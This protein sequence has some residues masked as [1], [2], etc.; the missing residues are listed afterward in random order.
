MSFWRTFGFHTISQVETIL[1]REHFTLEELLDEEELL[2]ECKSHN[3]KLIEYLAKTETLHQLITYLTVEPD[4]NAENKRKMR[5]PL[6]ACEILCSELWAV[7]DAIFEN[8]GHLDGL[9]GYLNKPTL[10]PMLVGYISKVVGTLL[11]KKSI[12][13]MN[14]L[15]NKKDA[16]FGNLLK[17]LDNPSI[18]ELLIKIIG[19]E[20][21]EPNGILHW[22]SEA[23][24]ISI[25]INKLSPMY[26][27]EVHENAAQ[28]LVEITLISHPSSPLLAQIE[29]QEAITQLFDLILA[30]G[31][32]PS[33]LSSGLTILMELFKKTSQESFNTQAKL[34]TLAPV[35]SVLVKN[36]E[37]FNKLL[38]DPANKSTLTLTTGTIVPLGIIRLKIVEFI[39]CL[40]KTNYA[41]LHHELVTSGLLNACLDL[42]F[43]FVWNNFLHATM[44]CI[45]AT[46]FDGENQDLKISLVKDCHLFDRIV[47][48]NKEN[49]AAVAEPKGMRR[50]NMAFITRIA[51]LICLEAQRNEPLAKL[52]EAHEGWKLFV[53]TSL[54]KT[55]Q[56]EA[57]LGGHKPLS[58]EPTTSEEEEEGF[59]SNGSPATL[60]FTQY[61]AQQ[62]FTNVYP[63][64]YNDEEYEDGEGERFFDAD[65]EYDTPAVFS[66]DTHEEEGNDNRSGGSGDGHDHSGS[67]SEEEVSFTPQ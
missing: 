29:S 53:S 12:E 24:L 42:F 58:L 14:F 26:S 30:P 9:Y 21:A 67:S 55:Q 37:K 17:H 34:E 44:D 43:I 40:I 25:L 39:L 38:I 27:A 47:A 7:Y 15:K 49:E 45:L 18:I 4:E 61:L 48:A 56:L 11:Q 13:S 33:I 54:A 22:L 63:D 41:C 36:F 32:N 60:V 46:I 8:E 66:G 16:I 23:N 2:Q 1:E 6:L 3:K 28:A 52:V 64:D 51:N 31:D 62:G 35:H 10:N 5:Y 59:D 50:G 19:S 57:P 20:A 65:N